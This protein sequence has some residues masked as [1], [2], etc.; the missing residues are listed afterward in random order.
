VPRPTR[1]LYAARRWR[2]VAG[3]ALALLACASIGPVAVPWAQA[4]ADQLAFVAGSAAGPDLYVIDVSRSRMTRLARNLADG[5]GPVWSPDGAQ[6]AF[7][8]RAG[9]A[10]AIFVVR[11]DGSGLRQLA[12]GRSLSWSPDGTRIA[13]GAT[14]GDDEEVFVLD[15]RSMRSERLT[16]QQ[17]R[18]ITPLWSPDGAGIAFASGRGESSRLQG[19]EY[20]TEIYLMNADGSAARALTASNACGLAN[21]SE[22]KLNQLGRAAWTPD[23]RRLL[24]RAGV[25]KFDCKVCVIDVVDGRV[26]PLVAER[27][28][29]DFAVSPDGKAVAYAWNRQILVMDLATGA[30]R[31][32]V[33]GAWGPA[34]SPD[35]RRIAFLV[36][37]SQEVGARS[38]HIE[39]IE[40]D[41]RNRRRVTTQSGE[42]WS[43]TWSPPIPRP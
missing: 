40:P 26:S 22:G 3:A 6:L 9:Q 23:G 17:G 19:L 2:V 36:P 41:G 8:A 5:A 11:S 20:G 4:G 24:Y 34:W 28:V 37:A 38:Y 13:F 16:T 12:P 43:L 1:P 29:G 42:Y 32:L 39:T 27:M 25:C 18:D 31:P 35:G 30:R 10:S 15:L 7:T 14:Q 33:Q 21:E